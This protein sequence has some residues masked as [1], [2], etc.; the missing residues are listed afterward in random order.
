MGLSFEQGPQAPRRPPPPRGAGPGA[1]RRRAA[2]DRALSLALAS[3]IGLL[4]LAALPARA[5]RAQAPELLPCPQNRLYNAG[6]EGG[7]DDRG[8][9]A[10][11]VG[12]GWQPWARGQDLS[13]PDGTL[14]YLPL[15]RRQRGDDTVVQQGWWAQGVEG[16]PQGATAGLWQR[17]RLPLGARVLVYAWGGVGPA[18]TDAPRANGEP[19][20]ASWLLRLGWDPQGGSDPDQPRLLWTAPLTLTSAWAPLALPPFAAEATVG[21]LFLEGRRLG[22][23]EGGDAGQL[24]WD[25]ACVGLLD[26][27]PLPTQPSPVPLITLDPRSP[28]PPPLETLAIVLAGQAQATAA[29]QALEA[30]A[31]QRAGSAA[32]RLSG[33]GAA[34]FQ[35][36]GQHGPVPEPPP[37]AQADWS[38]RIYDASGLLLL[39]LAAALA[40]LMVAR[41]GGPKPPPSAS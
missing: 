40:G 8:R 7:F 35:V 23:R 14:R 33:G 29:A 27:P 28:E 21:T 11:Q 37:P 17:V 13:N 4:A 36:S 20:A 31:T 30:R 22:A 41:R 9:P 6:F 5:L 26:A 10:I 34:P 1:P 24:R 15:S 3:A 2:A 25:G 38:A 16:L 39:L 32:G 19:G 18:G 12:L